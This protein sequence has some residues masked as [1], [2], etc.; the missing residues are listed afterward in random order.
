MRTKTV[1]L[2]KYTHENSARRCKIWQT[3]H[4]LIFSSVQ[5]GNLNCLKT[6]A[7]TRGSGWNLGN[8]IKI[9]RADPH[10]KFSA[11]LT[12]SNSI[13]GSCIRDLDYCSFFP[14]LTVL[15]V[16][17]LPAS[18]AHIEGIHGI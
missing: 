7:K 3:N 6:I 16:N 15:D 14:R 8:C 17:V 2:A 9:A 13:A 12:P 5:T 18:R 4:R 10:C 1:S 11:S